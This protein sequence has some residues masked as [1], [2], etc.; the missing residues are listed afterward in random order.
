MPIIVTVVF[1]NTMVSL[2]KPRRINGLYLHD[3]F[4]FSSHSLVRVQEST[5]RDCQGKQCSSQVYV[6]LV[7]GTNLENVEACI[8]FQFVSFWFQILGTQT[9]EEA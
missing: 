1:P 4:N 2:D 5:W 3:V 8:M 6:I 9:C 7:H